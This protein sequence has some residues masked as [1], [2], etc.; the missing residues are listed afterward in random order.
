MAE[1]I[2]HESSAVEWLHVGN[3][4]GLPTEI[5]QMILH[6]LTIIDDPPTHWEQ[7]VD[8][9]SYTPQPIA[10]FGSC[11]FI[12]YVSLQYIAAMLAGLTLQYFTTQ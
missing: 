2:I 5:S 11:R 7:V 6:K 12:F 10:E 1:G 8:M 4:I 9:L 3:R